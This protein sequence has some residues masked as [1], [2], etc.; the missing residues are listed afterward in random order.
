RHRRA[1]HRLRSHHPGLRQAVAGPH[2]N[3]GGT[4]MSSETDN[5]IAISMRGVTK[6]F[7]PDPQGALA[8]L[9]AGKSKSELL[10]ESGHVVGLDNVSLDI[11]RG[12]IF[13]VMGLSGSGKSTLI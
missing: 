11:K 10:A 1:C 7:G 12:E 6:I 5:G 3:R 2:R 9:R 13:V 8:A 4:P